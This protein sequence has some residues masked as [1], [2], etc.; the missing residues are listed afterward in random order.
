[1]R[2]GNFTPTSKNLARTK[3]WGPL[4]ASRSGLDLFDI[5]FPRPR[6]HH[7]KRILWRFGHGKIA[8]IIKFLLRGGL[9]APRPRPSR[10]RRRRDSSARQ[11]RGDVCR[12]AKNASLAAMADFCN[13]FAVRLDGRERKPNNG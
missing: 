12:G 13:T 3:D 11:W 4:C 1:M 8:R 6:I 2:E 10:H 5:C 9:S 7:Q